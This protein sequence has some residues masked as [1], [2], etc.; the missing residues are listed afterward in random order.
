MSN[1]TEYIIKRQEH[2]EALNINGT[3]YSTRIL[4]D[5][6]NLLIELKKITDMF[7]RK[8]YKKFDIYFKI[9]LTIKP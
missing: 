2:T 1:L 7:G 5:A 9:A 3:K 4:E 6:Q 8:K